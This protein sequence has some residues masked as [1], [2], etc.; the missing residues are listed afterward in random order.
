MDIST[1]F[2]RI[3][4][5]SESCIEMIDDYWNSIVTYYE[6]FTEP[7]MLV[8]NPLYHMGAIYTSIENVIEL[9]RNQDRLA[10]GGW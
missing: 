6:V 1:I 4:P 3:H 7:L 8:Y 10:E 2:R 5:M 9:I